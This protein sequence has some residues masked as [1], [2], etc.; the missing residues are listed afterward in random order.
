MIVCRRSFVVVYMLAMMISCSKIPI[1]SFDIDKF[2]ELTNS[3]EGETTSFLFF[4]DPHINENNSTFEQYLR[5]LEYNYNR[6]PLEF[7]LCGGDWL[8]NN[9]TNQQAYEKL[10]FIADYTYQVFG[11]NYYTILGNHDTNYQ[12]RLNDEAE[13]HTGLLSHEDIVDLLFERQGNSFYSFYSK[14][15]RFLVLDTGIDWN[16][17]MDDHRW[18]QAHWFANELQSN[19][20]Q[21]LVVAMHIYTNDIDGT[22]SPELFSKYI[23]EIAEAHNNRKV[24]SLNGVEYDFADA[25]G[26]VACVLCGHCHEDFIATSSCSIPIVGTTHLKDGN[27]PTFDMCVFNWEQ[28]VLNLLR[29]GSGNDRII[30]LA[31]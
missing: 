5:S 10:R 2:V 17:T 7:C 19:E 14:N 30:H 23:M 15:A 29:V 22:K 13:L 28:N 21:H 18:G 20:S 31:Q 25:Y 12:G 1:E 3:V 8:N 26:K 11:D 4:T 24:I 9:D 16:H 27:I 6:V